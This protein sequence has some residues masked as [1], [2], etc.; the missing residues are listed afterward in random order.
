MRITI[1]PDDTF[2]SIDEDGLFG[3]DLSWIPKFTGESGVP[4]DVHALQWYDTYG[5][6]ELKSRDNNIKI[7][8]LGVFEQVI[9][10]FEERKSQILKENQSTFNEI[11]TG[12]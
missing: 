5:E 2:V 4:T 11:N 7:N 9:L 6:V 1:I 10:K 12:V 3:V 8:E